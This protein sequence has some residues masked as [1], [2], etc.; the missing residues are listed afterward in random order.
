M[1]KNTQ[2]SLRELAELLNARLVGDENVKITAMAPLYRASNGEITFLL[3]NKYK[4]QLAESTASAIVLTE[5]DLSDYQG[6]ALIMSDPNIGYAKLAQLFINKQ[7]LSRGVHATAIIAG[8]AKIAESAS[9]GP[10][11]VIGE[12]VSVGEGTAIGAGSVIG[13]DCAIGSECIIYP[14]VSFYRNVRLQD[15][16]IVHSGVVLGADGF[17]MVND[18]GIWRKIPQLGGV[19]IG[20]DVEIGANTTIDCGAMDDTIIGDGVKMDNQ[21][22]IAHNVIIGAHT[23]VAGC[24]AIAGST[25]IGKHCMIGGRVAITDH[26]KICDQVILTGGTSVTKSITTPGIYSSTVSAQPHSEWQRNTVRSRQLEKLF[27]RVK[28]LE[29]GIDE[30]D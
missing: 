19:L 30:Q 20:N 22:Q 9:I 2:Y 12:R 28:Q 18:R 26:I 4:A 16:V 21:I 10:F 17:G 13:D 6:N 3:N 1:A 15:R 8:T 14:K 25:E 11:V 24:V 23:A 27:N 29:Q 5:Q 7:H